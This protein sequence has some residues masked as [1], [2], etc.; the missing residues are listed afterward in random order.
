[1][2]DLTMDPHRDQLL[3][4]SGIPLSEASSMMIL[5]HGRGASAQNM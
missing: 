3:L 4:R 5:L 2:I 1:M